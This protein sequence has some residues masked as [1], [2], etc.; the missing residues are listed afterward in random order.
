MMRIIYI[1]DLFVYKQEILMI[2]KFTFY[3][4]THIYRYHREKI[5]TEATNMLGFLKFKSN[6]RFRNE[7][8]LKQK[9]ML[10]KLIF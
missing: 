2:F 5:F 6:K 8:T 3:T 10:F 1:I 7:I 4:M 9:C